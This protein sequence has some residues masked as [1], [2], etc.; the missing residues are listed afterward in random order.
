MKANLGR[1][2]PRKDPASL[3]HLLSKFIHM[4]EEQDSTALTVVPECCGSHSSHVRYYVNTW[5]QCYYNTTEVLR[6]IFWP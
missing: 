4:M 1:T 3:Y 5:P 2:D 6:L